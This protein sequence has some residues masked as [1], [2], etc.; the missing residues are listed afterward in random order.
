VFPSTAFR[1]GQHDP[2]DDAVTG[3]PRDNSTSVAACAA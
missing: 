1:T 2:D 3:L